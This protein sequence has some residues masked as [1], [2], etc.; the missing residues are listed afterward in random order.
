MEIEINNYPFEQVGI[1][2]E[3]IILK[4]T[5][6]LKQCVEY[7]QKE[8]K[9]SGFIKKDFLW[10]VDAFENWTY[11]EGGNAMI[12]GDYPSVIT[13]TTSMSRTNVS[14]GFVV[15]DKIKGKFLP[16]E[17]WRHLQITK[18]GADDIFDKEYLKKKAELNNKVKKG[19]KLMREIASLYNGAT[20][21]IIDKLK[22]LEQQN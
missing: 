14:D 2:P 6:D 20:D 3:V 22:L 18:K 7:V 13:Y 15:F 21:K 17:A 19:Y 4:T 10:L 16:F 9:E 11:T 8:R 1:V 5:N 12:G